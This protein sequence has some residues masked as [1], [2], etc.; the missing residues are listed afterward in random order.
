M[1]TSILVI[2]WFNIREYINVTDHINC[3]E[4]DVYETTLEQWIDYHGDPAPRK[5]HHLP[6]CKALEAVGKC[7]KQKWLHINRM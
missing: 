7:N 2:E 6:K 5:L 1:C 4:K 3:G